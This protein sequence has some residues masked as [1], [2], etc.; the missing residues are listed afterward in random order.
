MIAIALLALSSIWRVM[1]GST[2]KLQSRD[3]T[4]LV[5]ISLLI[6][7]LA[8]PRNV[9]QICQFCKDSGWKVR[10]NCLEY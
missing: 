7:K 5:L 2:F 4:S 6:P 10:L 8:L 1:T 9:K 3:K